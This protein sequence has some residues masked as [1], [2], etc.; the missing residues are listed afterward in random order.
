M[1]QYDAACP[2]VARLPS[3]LQREGSSAAPARAAES[4]T[5][6]GVLYLTATPYSSASDPQGSC[7]VVPCKT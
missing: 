6:L 3:W 7:T 5:D 4:M 2:G 1:T